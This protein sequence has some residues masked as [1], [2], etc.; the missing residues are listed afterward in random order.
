MFNWLIEGG[1]TGDRDLDTGL[2][3]RIWDYDAKRA[4]AREKKHGEYDLPSQNLGY[5]ILLKLG[6]L[7]IAAPAGEERAVWEPV[8]AHGPAAHHALQ[9]FIRGL[10]LRLRKG[11]DPVAFERVWRATAEY[12]LT[13]DWS[14]SGLW[15]YGER[16]IC[17]LLGFGNEDALSR[18]YPGAA[19]RMKDL[20]NRWAAAH[21][22]RDEGCVTR[23]CH[24]LTTKFGA[25]L[26]LDGLRWLA[27]MLKEREPSSRWYREGTGDALVALVAAALSSDAQALSQ[28]PQAR[29]ALVEIAAALAAMN[30]P[31]A[32]AL[33][34]RIQQLR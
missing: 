24:F 33:Q 29:Q 19:L 4:K 25:P 17:D 26:R 1:G 13:A 20:Y 28:H 8:L 22:A 32:L 34:E 9:H 14:Q 18:L 11:D 7:S 2:A 30:V 3:L 12:G 31:T 15:F 6:A 5:D 16:L 27:A 23:F 10:F 21:L